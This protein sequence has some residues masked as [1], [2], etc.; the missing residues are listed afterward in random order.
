RGSGSRDSRPAGRD[1]RDRAALPRGQRDSARHRRRSAPAHRLPRARGGGARVT[2][3]ILVVLA[4]VALLAGCGG[5]K[6]AAPPADTQPKPKPN[7]KPKPAYN[8]K[9]TKLVVTIL[10]GDRRVRVRGAR[11][12][13]WGKTGR[14]NRHG[15]TTILAPRGK[16]DVSVTRRGYAPVT[17]PVD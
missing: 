3:R 7:P 17:M 11:V 15:E 10:D 9:L 13:L 1:R 14:T 12:S 5:S 8:H 4:L 2:P 16:H 6:Q